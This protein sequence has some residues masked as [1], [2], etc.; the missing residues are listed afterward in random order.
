MPRSLLAV[1][2]TTSLLAQGGPIY[3]VDASSGPGT[4]YTDIQAAVLA[5]PDGSTL[6]VRPG[7]YGTVVIDGKGISILPDPSFAITPVSGA[8]LVV[9]NTQ[10]HQRVLVRGI[11]NGGFASGFLVQVTN[12]A[13]PV[14]LDGV[15]QSLSSDATPLTI[16]GSPQVDVRRWNLVATH[17]YQAFPACSIT[18]SSVVF[19]RCSLT[20][21][22]SIAS[23]IP[24]SGSPALSVAS[25]NV[26]VI[27]TSLVGGQGSV[28]AFSPPR[29]GAPAVVMN[30]SSLR[31]MGTGQIR[32]GFTPAVGQLPAITGSGVV[33]VDP[34]IPMTATPIGVNISPQTMPSLLADSAPP[35][36]VVT[37]RRSGAPSMPC[38]VAVSLRA[39]HSTVPA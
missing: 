2:L 8:L 27:D 12:A 36:G 5:V 30:A 28:F 39:P 15:D 34:H 35:G 19:E 24:N 21:G 25:S 31:A 32:G 26:Q 9:R 6:L 23:K 14:T 18:N 37:V 20:G 13:G 38:V 10:A 17:I 1:A 22:D 33:R 29:P 3:V 11:V 16:T 4:N 7:T